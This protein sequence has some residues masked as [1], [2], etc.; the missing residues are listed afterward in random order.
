MIEIITCIIFCIV[1]IVLSLST[2]IGLPGGWIFFAIAL[3]LEYFDFQMGLPETSFGGWALGLSFV[4]LVGSELIEFFAGALGAKKGGG[5]KRGMWWSLGGSI[6]GAI[7][8]TF[9]IP[10]P[11]FGS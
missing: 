3:M 10:V 5:S 2:I 8:G 11:L 7:V 4:F 6:V 9:L 1:S